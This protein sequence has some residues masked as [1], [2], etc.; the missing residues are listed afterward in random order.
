MSFFSPPFSPDAEDWRFCLLVY[1]DFLHGG[2]DPSRTDLVC[3]SLPLS[4]LQRAA[5]PTFS[6]AITS[7]LSHAADVPTSDWSSFLKHVR[8]DYSGQEVKVSQR[9]T[10]AQMLPALPPKGARARI[11][12]SDL[13]T[14]FVREALLDPSLLLR[15]SA[16][17]PDTFATAKV[18]CDSSQWVPIVRH[19]FDIGM[20][21]FLPFSNL[22]FR[23]GR[24]LLNG[25]FGVSKRG[26]FLE[27][28]SD[29]LRFVIN[30]IPAN[31]LRF[32][33]AA[34]IATLPSAHQWKGF[35]LL[36]D[37][38]VSPPEEDTVASFYL[39]ALPPAWLPYTALSLPVSAAD[40]SDSF[41]PS[42]PPPRLS[43]RA[44]G[45]RAWGGSP[46]AGSC[47]TCTGGCALSRIPLQI[48]CRPSLR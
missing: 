30:M 10:L 47:S 29:V 15:P 16:E 33:L 37:E 27:D 13:A 8:V 35:E 46:P 22:L 18:H 17:W 19:L 38:V 5:F 32:P 2:A 44:F 3:S 31:A 25:A 14:G 45:S 39:F 9:L 28:G 36:S 1:I 20:I 40:I 7:W 11:P 34:D 21:S 6:R 23:G 42:H 26:K 41:R 4:K 12:T 24:P 48:P 43:T